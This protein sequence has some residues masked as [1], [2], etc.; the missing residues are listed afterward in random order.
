MQGT[1]YVNQTRSL[2]PQRRFFVKPQVT[3]SI[4]ALAKRLDY[5]SYPVAATFLLYLLFVISRLWYFDFNPTAFIVAGDRVADKDILPESFL[6]L[7]SS[8]GYDGQFYYAIAVSPA[9][10]DQEDTGI[11]GV[12][13]YRHQRILYPLIVW[14]F[15]LGKKGWVPYSM[16]AVNL[17]AVCWIAWLAGRLCQTMQKNALWG[18]LISLYPGYLLSLSRNLAEITAGAFILAALWLI[19]RRRNIW[20]AIALSFGILAR[21][22]A[23]VVA[24]SAIL[25][26]GGAYL[27]N[28]RKSDFRW[29]VLF[30]PILVYGLWQ[31]VLWR[32]WG[33]PAFAK[34]GGL[35]GAPLEGLLSSLASA[36]RLKHISD[37]A[38]CC[39]LAFIVFFTT[40]ALLCSRRTTA[41]LL[42]R[43]SLTFYGAMVFVL[44]DKVWIE[45][46]GYFRASSELF[47]FGFLILIA[48]PSRIKTPITVFSIF[49]WTSQALARI[50]FV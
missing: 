10:P 47:L 31:A 39:D 34:A 28:P 45:N 46:L 43:I 15:S 37:F 40:T 22:T 27:R 14:L 42:Y 12:N 1:P 48:A 8:Y 36:M 18:L 13:A 9:R 35:I 50:F 5:P 29:M 6:V 38:V 19:T 16:I 44:S 20:A 11:R 25:A 3:W 32:Y 21:E 17:A 7:E 26:S 23:L 24:V 41:P 4:G 2:F 33:S 49:R 30:M